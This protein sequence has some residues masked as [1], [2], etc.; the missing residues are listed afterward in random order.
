MEKRFFTFLFLTLLLYVAYLNLMHWFNPPAPAPGKPG[1]VAKAVPGEVAPPK[2]VQPVIP[3][4]NDE[5]APVR[6]PNL[7]EPPLLRT[8]LGSLDPN[9]PYRMLVLLNNTGASVERIE[10][11]SP[12]YRKVQDRP[13]DR[14]GYLGELELKAVEQGLQ[15]QVVGPGTPAARA[16]LQPGDV[17]TKIDAQP[18]SR[19]KHLQE[20]LDLNTRDGQLV[21]LLVQRGAD[22]PLKLS[23]T[24]IRRPLQLVATEPG[25]P[26]SLLLTLQQIGDGPELS[27]TSL[28]E[29]PGVNLRSKHWRLVQAKIDFAEFETELPNLGLRVLK[30]YRLGKVTAQEP[31]PGAE[32]PAYGLLLDL[33]F[34]N[35][36]TQPLQIAYRL[37]GLR[38]LPTE[39]DWYA[40]KV[41]GPGLRDITVS[42]EGTAPQL[43][44]CAQVGDP[45]LAKDQEWSRPVSFIGV[46]AQFF[47]GMLI[48]NSAE[49]KQSDPP[50]LDRA[51][52]VRI[53]IA[54]KDR[55]SLNDTSV[56]VF[57][58]PQFVNANHSLRS[59]FTVFAGPKAPE[60]LEPYGLALLN[61]Y[62]SFAWIATLLLG[63]LHFFSSFTGN[64]GLAIVVLTVLVRLCLLPLT[65]YQLVVMQN[66]Q[67]QNQKIQPELKR[68]K[69]KYKNDR[70]AYNRAQMELFQKHGI[71]P[72]APLSGCL[73]ML[74]QL[75]IFIGLYTG[76]RADIELRQAPLIA[77]WF[78]WCVDLSAPDML[79]RWDSFMPEF[80][81]SPTG[82]FKLGPYF[83]LLPIISTVCIYFAQKMSMPPPPP[84]NDELAEQQRINQQVFTV[85]TF[86]MAMM[87]YNLPSGLCV[88][89]ITSTG[90]G[91]M[92][93]LILPKPKAGVP[94]PE[95]TDPPKKSPSIWNAFLPDEESPN[96]PITNADNGDKKKKKQR[97]RK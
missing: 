72:L 39:G 21:N 69:E 13:E 17:I 49:K 18:L 33:E 97:G 46:D 70:P 74:L 26:L 63:V 24:L 96:K 87:F 25:D 29:L 9:S 11:N 83:N 36:G 28:T 42:F 10:L 14:G 93:R 30:R 81:I 67:E 2:V 54:H 16:G 19:P 45:E 65:R 44:P 8:Y 37:E 91:M 35:L 40:Y 71:N 3:E 57:S 43:I 60:V 41:H 88:Y 56:R 78:P 58:K 1:E 94:R 95:P 6:L 76:L 55:P 31:T 34:S 15:V 22:E 48:P 75:P 7:G 86:V 79:F 66:L 50:Q 5:A 92:E 84:G 89:F 80:L 85:M 77:E 20:F 73:P 12:R 32:A 53:G 4:V 64:Y 23:A 27:T 51:Q 59:S 38:G 47:A 52:A 90:W 68:L 62:G 82:W 61:D